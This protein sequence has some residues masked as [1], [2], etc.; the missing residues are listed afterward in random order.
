VDVGGIVQSHQQEGKKGV[1]GK[2]CKRQ[3]ILI[4]AAFARG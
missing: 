1:C 4:I 2:R 3:W